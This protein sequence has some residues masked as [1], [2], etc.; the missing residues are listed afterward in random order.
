MNIRNWGLH[1]I[2]QLP[3][4]CFG[5]RFAISCFVSS[6]QGAEAWD[7]AEVAFPERFVLWELSIWA[8][9]GVVPADIFG[10][11]MGD[12]LPTTAAMFDVLEPLIPGLG[13]TMAE[14]RDIVLPAYASV[15]IRQL[16]CPIE[17]KGR[18]MVLMLHA[19]GETTKLLQVVAV[20]SSLP[21]EAPDWLI[22][23]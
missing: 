18:R 16:R 11:A 17:A 8:P 20:V 23:R 7:I 22:S 2:M 13:L 21:T 3:D 9:S 10:L 4:S 12:Q 1:K 15:G 19:S 14:P 5:R 6:E